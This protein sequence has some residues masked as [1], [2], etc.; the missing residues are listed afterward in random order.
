MKILHTADWHLGKRLERFERLPEQEQVLAELI[1]LV[2]REQPDAIL[3]AGDLFDTFNPPNDAVELFYRTLKRLA[4]NG[5]RPVIAIAGNHDSPQ[6]IEVPEPL[7]R[8]CGILFF[9]FPTTELRPF[10]LPDGFSLTQTAPGFLEISLPQFPDT[11]LRIIA[12][13]Y[14]N[15]VRLKQA[16]EQPG[17]LAEAL[18][19]HWQALADEYCDDQGVNILVTHLFMAGSEAEAPDEPDGE[20]P[21]RLGN[22]DLIPTAILPRQIQYAALGHLHRYQQMQGP[23]P[24]IYPGSPLAYSFS[25]ANQSKYV[26]MIDVVA[27]LAAQWERIPLEAGFP[28]L[29]KRFE[30]PDAA[31]VWL[32][33][34]P[35]CY[36]E[37]TIATETFLSSVD[38]KR[39][40]EAHARMVGPIPDLGGGDNDGGSGQLRIDL[41]R[42]RSELFAD[43]FQHETGQKASAEILYL[44]DE[45]LSQEGAP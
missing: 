14:A 42:S 3:I 37:L 23:V 44:L 45:I 7:A 2:E 40:V 36:V 15:E 24:V 1:E 18:G 19:A 32:R 17:D 8:E 16:L 26:V 39:L 4:D 11:P 12:T 10:A 27:G 35:E 41:T 34:N 38:R 22:A 30:D 29:R 43:Y 20:K 13:P 25:E 9:G 21:I 6:R 28:V 31:V 33:D 5:R